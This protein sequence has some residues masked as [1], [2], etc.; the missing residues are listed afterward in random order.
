[1]KKQP[2]GL[3]QRQDQTG[4]ETRTGPEEKGERT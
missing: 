4:R 3:G 1:M 2:G